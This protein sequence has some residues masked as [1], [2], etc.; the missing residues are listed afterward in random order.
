MLSF[1]MNSYGK[2]S[3][4]ETQVLESVIRDYNKYRKT[5]KKFLK[6]NKEALKIFEALKMQE[7]PK[8]IRT[9]KRNVI[10]IS[11]KGINSTLEIL[12]VDK[13]IFKVNGVKFKKSLKTPFHEGF[14]RVF[15]ILEK[16]YKPQAPSKKVSHFFTLFPEAQASIQFVDRDFK[17]DYKKYR[18]QKQAAWGVGI[19]GVL[20]GIYTAAKTSAT[21]SL[22]TAGHILGVGIIITSLISSVMIGSEANR[23]LSQKKTYKTEE[24]EIEEGGKTI[25]VGVKKVDKTFEF[26]ELSS[27]ELSEILDSCK[28]T[29][30]KMEEFAK[31]NPNADRKKFL[32]NF[33]EENKNEVIQLKTLASDLKK[34]FIFNERSQFRVKRWW[35]QET[36]GAREAYEDAEKCLRNLRNELTNYGLGVTGFGDTLVIDSNR[37][38]DAKKEEEGETDSS[39]ESKGSEK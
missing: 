23:E 3:S 8:I 6:N 20:G 28:K 21:S 31:K 22:G 7:F 9:S 12:D 39:S 1:S 13:G 16:Q 34:V 24:K 11:Y 17:K 18:I 30:E 14:L 38:E 5:P 35:F 26:Q 29:L 36:E 37:D 10:K 27:A 2:L 25:T 19:G 4:N 33:A 15:Y 32:D